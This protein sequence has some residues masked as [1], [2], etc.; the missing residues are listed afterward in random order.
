MPAKNGLEFW[1]MT[2]WSHIRQMLQNVSRKQLQI[3]TSSQICCV[4]STK[5]NIYVKPVKKLHAS[6]SCSFIQNTRKLLQM[7]VLSLQDQTLFQH[8]FVICMCWPNVACSVVVVYIKLQ[9]RSV[10]KSDKHGTE[11]TLPA[12]EFSSDWTSLPTSL[13]CKLNWETNS[14]C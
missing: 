9:M 10:T 6:Y 8:H 3:T 2:H 4:W 7:H 1:V 11:T 12:V 13:W 14:A 5:E